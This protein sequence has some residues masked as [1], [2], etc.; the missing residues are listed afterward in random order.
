M[1][2][3]EL[4]PETEY[5]HKLTLRLLLDQERERF[6]ALLGEAAERVAKTAAAG[7]VAGSVRSDVPASALGGVLVALALGFVASIEVGAPFD[8]AAARSA[9]LALLEPRRSGDAA[10]DDR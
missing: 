9:V 8:A 3:P 7:Q 5:L 6:V 10:Q 1:A 4:M 2:K